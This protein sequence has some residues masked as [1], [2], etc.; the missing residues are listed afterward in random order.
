MSSGTLA[1]LRTASSG[2]ALR[3]RSRNVGPGKQTRAS[4]ATRRLAF[5]FSLPNQFP[6]QRRRQR[7][8]H[9][10]WS[11]FVCSQRS[12]ALTEHCD[13]ALLEIC[14]LRPVSIMG[15]GRLD[16][17][18]KLVIPHLRRSD[19]HPWMMTSAIRQSLRFIGGKTRTLGSQRDWYLF[20]F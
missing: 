12:V 17:F 3:G 15:Y 8:P 14:G 11:Q 16:D 18:S 19:E 2:V 20:F 7:R 9:M 6:Q 4:R 10:Q 5:F 13:F 1:P